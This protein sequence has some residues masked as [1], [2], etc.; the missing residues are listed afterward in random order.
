[1]ISAFF[2][3]TEKVYQWTMVG[4]FM[5][6]RPVW[7]TFVRRGTVCSE[8][9][10][11]VSF[12]FGNRGFLYKAD[13]VVAV[14][15]VQYCLFKPVE[16]GRGDIIVRKSDE[17]KRSAKRKAADIESERGQQKLRFR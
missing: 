4:A 17:V 7:E 2:A 6:D 14:R 15:G 10:R 5:D 1:M 12:L 9:T 13:R 8:P 3:D 11:M 16:A